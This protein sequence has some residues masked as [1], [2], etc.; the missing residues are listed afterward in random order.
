MKQYLTVILTLSLL[1]S[2][3]GAAPAPET[4]PSTAVTTEAT[5]PVETVQETTQETE[6]VPV[7]NNREYSFTLEGVELIPG[8]A[9]DASKL[10]KVEVYQET[11]CAFDTTDNIYM[12]DACE[13]TAYNLGDGEKVYSVFI[14]DLSAMT[15]EGLSL[16]DEEAKIVAAY[17]ENYN[18][19]EGQYTYI[20]RSS[21]LIIM[22]SSGFVESIEYRII[23]E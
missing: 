4:Q 15:P 9:F 16:G 14:T 22:T 18:L 7:I 2:A 6:S 5:E 21:Q 20:G 17:G 3:C 19:S 11:N 12:Y 13:V 8:Q 23:E 1:L 10:P